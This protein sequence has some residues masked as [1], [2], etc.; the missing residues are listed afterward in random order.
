MQKIET[1]GLKNSIKLMG[2]IDAKDLPG[3]YNGAVLLT[4]PA[5]YEGFG[6]PPLEAMGCGTPV[7]VSNISSMPEVV[8]DAGILVDPK[9]VD[10]IAD[11]LLSV[12]MDKKL[13]HELAAKGIERAREF[14]WEN[15]GRKTL[16]VMES[17]K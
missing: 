4:L 2:Y 10:S 14:S 13:Q 7:V 8:G 3:L 1:E 9:S 6:L 16:D 5:L 15:T 11:G 12:L 17:L